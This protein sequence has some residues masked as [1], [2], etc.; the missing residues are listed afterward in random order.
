MNGLKE[1]IEQMGTSFEAFRKSYDERVNALE[2]AVGRSVLPGGNGGSLSAESG[3]HR[4][5][6]LAYVRSGGNEQVLRDLEVRAALTTLSDPDAGFLIPEEV[7]KELDR[8]VT[9]SVAMRRLARI[10]RA[11]GDYKRP[12]SKGGAAAG[13]VGEVESRTETSTP[14]LHLFQPAW[15]E[16]YAMP[17]ASQKTLDMS[18]F[19][20]AA[21]LTDEI[22]I[23]F[24][25]QEGTGFISGNSVKQ[26]AGLLHYAT[27]ANASW[28]W[29]KLGYIA[30]GHASLLNDADKLFDLQTA[31]KPVHRANGKW[32]MNDTTAG[33]IRKLKDG[34]ARYIWR[35]GLEAG[36]PNMLLGKPV[37]IDDNMPDIGENTYPIAFGDFQRAY[38][39]VD[40]VVGTRVLRDP[41]SEKGQVLFYTTKRVTGGVTNF[42]A[43]KLLKIA[44]S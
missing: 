14:E 31:V 17:K 4:K 22:G 3:E 39:I 12:F 13:W 35:D 19:D 37:E 23:A 30:S 15:C 9:A 2:T 29:G 40:H 11:K 41:Y 6:F 24:V 36:I 20:V 26:P 43:V 32:L 27:V 7:D 28:V 8:L 16:I 5:A 34:E 42:Q 33:V 21:W 10:V 38:T 18:D 1:I 44:A 25:E